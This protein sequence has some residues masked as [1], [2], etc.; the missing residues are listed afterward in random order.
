MRVAFFAPA[1]STHT[2]KWVNGMH[3]LGHEIVLFSLEHE[4]A[5]IEI[6]DS[7]E[8]VY[9]KKISP[10]YIYQL[11]GLLFRLQFPKYGHFDVISVHYASSY[12]LFARYAK[13]KN[14]ILSVWGSDVFKYPFYNKRNYK[15]IKKNLE[16]ASIVT[17]SSVVMKEKV[18]EITPEIQ[19]TVI[20]FG[21]DLTKFKPNTTKNR[22]KVK[23]IIAKRWEA[24]YGIETLIEASR[25]LVDKGF[26]FE[27]DIYGMGS[28][29]NSY[30]ELIIKYNLESY[31]NLMGYIAND[32]LPLV[33]AEADICVLTSHYESFGVAAI[34]AM[35]CGVPVIAT[36]TDGFT[37]II[38]NE[39]SGL[40]Y[41]VSD[42]KALAEKIIYLSTNNRHAKDISENA[43][44][45]VRNKYDF[46]RNLEQM[47]S[48]FEHIG[49]K[50][51]M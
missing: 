11:S 47:N 43:L 4:V 2:A 12:G 36:N 5:T 49:H 3:R 48:V 9:I 35:A 22:S 34:E 16:N 51:Q 29:E 28:L 38:E 33:L 10:R 8:I 25:V 23:I 27:V 31:V 37:E 41:P 6:E 39:I 7:I 24:H 42:Y 19:C 45:L 21:V 30:R 50:K 32:N 46:N 13:L 26:D 18:K 17:S 44:Q 1:N 14:Y 15:M 40:I 20:P